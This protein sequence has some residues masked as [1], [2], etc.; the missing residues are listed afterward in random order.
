MK[1]VLGGEYFLSLSLSLSLPLQELG[2]PSEEIWT[3][4]S[5]LPLV[6]KVFRH[7]SMVLRTAFVVILPDEEACLSLSPFDFLS[8]PSLALCPG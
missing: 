1:E 6:K 3:G 5:Q 7:C 4:Y 8:P 2:T